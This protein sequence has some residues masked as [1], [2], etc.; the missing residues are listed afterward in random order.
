MLIKCATTKGVDY[1]KHTISI[2][3]TTTVGKRCHL[4]V[5]F[6]PLL[7]VNCGVGCGVSFGERGIK[8]GRSPNPSSLPHQ[9]LYNTLSV[10]SPLPPCLIEKSVRT[11]E[12]QAQISFQMKDVC[13][14][15]FGT[16]L[17]PKP[18]SSLARIS[19][20]QKPS[21]A[22]HWFSVVAARG[23]GESSL[24]IKKRKSKTKPQVP[25]VLF[26]RNFS[27]TMERYLGYNRGNWI[28][29]NSR[30]LSEN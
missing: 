21:W 8:L 22:G 26:K 30:I 25:F 13:P 20:A 10:Q 1:L 17:T 18:Y 24:S 5:H 7:H 28:W 6:V 9:Q 12:A 11:P 29:S 3:I 16:I 15:L 23:S 4:L 19:W 2:V 14:G 27:P